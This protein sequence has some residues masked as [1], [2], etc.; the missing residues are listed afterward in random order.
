[1]A[2]SNAPTIVDKKGR[3]RH[4]IYEAVLDELEMAG[5]SKEQIEDFKLEVEYR[6]KHKQRLRV[7]W[8]QAAQNDELSNIE[9]MFINAGYSVEEASELTGF[10]KKDLLNEANWDGNKFKFGDQILVVDFSYKGSAFRRA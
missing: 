1:M 2:R 3:L 9:R 5:A 6:T 8:L 7:S 10:K 4:G